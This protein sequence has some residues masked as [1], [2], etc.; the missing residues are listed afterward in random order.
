MVYCDELRIILICWTSTVRRGLAKG[1]E[2]TVSRK[3]AKKAEKGRARS[4][5][6]LATLPLSKP[7]AK[8]RDYDVHVLI[9]KGGDCRR[10][11]SKDVRKAFK[12][13]L[14]RRGRAGDVRIDAVDCLGLCK[15]GPNVVIYPGGAWYLG[16][17][18]DDVPEIVER[19]L[20]GDAP[21]ERLAASFGPRKKKK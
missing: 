5:G 2:E 1:P 20:E 16:L 21:V 13:Q 3:G 15:H 7:D 4:N 12:D 19:H 14:R 9:C 18:A 11:G 10:G 8:V 17:R 6:A